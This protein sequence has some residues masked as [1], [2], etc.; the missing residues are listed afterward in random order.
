M[1]ILSILLKNT[2]PSEP[3]IEDLIKQYGFPLKSINELKNLE[4]TLENEDSW[5][6][7]YISFLSSHILRLT[8]IFSFLD[9]F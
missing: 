8:W 7:W 5:L 9:L 4:E 6:N 2:A 1:E 3:V